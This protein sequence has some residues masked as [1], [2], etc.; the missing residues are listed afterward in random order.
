MSTRVPLAGPTPALPVT[1]L[2]SY[3][4]EHTY[5][6]LPSGD[7]GTLCSTGALASFNVQVQHFG[8]PSTSCKKPLLRDHV[9]HLLCSG[10]AS[11]AVGELAA[12]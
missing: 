9:A 11:K 10:G 4:P 8:C 2:A 1:S 12:E 5:E 6:V 7:R 3:A